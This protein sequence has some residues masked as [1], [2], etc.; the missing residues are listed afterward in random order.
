VSTYAE[1]GGGVYAVLARQYVYA[2]A[3]ESGD[4]ARIAAALE[5]L[6]ACTVRLPPDQR[7]SYFAEAAYYQ[8]VLTGESA[9]AR[10]WLEDARKITGAR[11]KEDWESYPLAAIAYAERNQEQLKEHL[12]R[13]IAELDRRPGISGAVTATRGN[14]VALLNA[15]VAS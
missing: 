15:A 10:E 7:R 13:V 2:Y 4:S 1:S 3:K 11:G 14:L 5:S 9:L 8:G 12:R 6:L